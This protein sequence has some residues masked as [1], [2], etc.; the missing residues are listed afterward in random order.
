MLTVFLLNR[1]K[2]VVDSG[3]YSQTCVVVAAGAGAANARLLV[4]CRPR[5]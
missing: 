4:V 1:D 3:C 5:Q 2:L